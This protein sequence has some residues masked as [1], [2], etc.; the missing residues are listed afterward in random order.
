MSQEKWIGR[1]TVEWSKL[2]AVLDD[3][4]WCF[5]DLPMEFGRTIT[6][7]MNAKSKVTMLRNLSTLTFDPLLQAYLKEHLDLVDILKDDRNF[8]V[9]GTWGRTLK[10]RTPYAMSLR[11]KGT[12]STV[13]AESFTPQRM[14]S[15]WQ[16]IINVKWKLYP[17]FDSAR[18]AHHRAREQFRILNESTLAQ[19]LQT[20][21]E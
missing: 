18:E 2:E 10:D 14:Q 13:V 1:I 11:P 6:T 8:I 20:K 19:H 7:T 4:I 9:H 16:L 15:I 12:A 5:L 17:L 3:L 21:P